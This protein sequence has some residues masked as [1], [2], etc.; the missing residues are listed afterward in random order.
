M[1]LPPALSMS[2]PLISRNVNVNRYNRIMSSGVS[3]CDL[4]TWF[5]RDSRAILLATSV[6]LTSGCK[7]MKQRAKGVSSTEHR[8]TLVVSDISL[9]YITFSPSRS[10]TQ[11][12]ANRTLHQPPNKARII[13]PLK[14][15]P[16]PQSAFYKTSTTTIYPFYLH[17]TKTYYI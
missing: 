16:A 4:R 15:G 14:I 5:P 7:R 8:Y 13:N 3:E 2:Q 9:T 6:S 12:I 10:T 17:L 1:I 11:R